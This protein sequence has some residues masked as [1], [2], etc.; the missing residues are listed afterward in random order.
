MIMLKNEL[1][2]SK[3]LGE[4]YNTCSASQVESKEGRTVMQVVMGQNE[5]H[6]AEDT[7][8]DT[9]TLVFLIFS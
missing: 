9:R 2:M 3:T 6:S 1:I 7:V 4:L 5:A 8:E